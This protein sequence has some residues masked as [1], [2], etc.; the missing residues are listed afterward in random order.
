MLRKVIVDNPWIL[1]P[2]S[3]CHFHLSFALFLVDTRNV[4]IVNAKVVNYIRFINVSSMLLQLAC[5]YLILYMPL[6][7]N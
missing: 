6:S 2:S 7:Y 3:H 4:S 1:Q 5:F